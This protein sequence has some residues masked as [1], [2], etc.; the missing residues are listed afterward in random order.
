MQAAEAP[1]PELL[2]APARKAVEERQGGRTKTAPVASFLNPALNQRT[3]YGV[4]FFAGA[5][6][7]AGFG[8]GVDAAGA[9]PPFTG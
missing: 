8:A 5:A 1:T 6:G 3:R 7:A 4:G 2:D 9:A